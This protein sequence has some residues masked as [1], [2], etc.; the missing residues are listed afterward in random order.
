MRSPCDM[1][2]SPQ[3]LAL[4]Y[5]LRLDASEAFIQGYVDGMR[6]DQR[7]QG[8]ACGRGWIPRSKKCSRDK[9][10][11]T[12]KEAKAK[13]VEKAKERAKLKS[14]V[15]S[16]KGQKPYVKPKP[17]ETKPKRPAKTKRITLKESLETP[18]EKRPKITRIAD[19]FKENDAP[20][21]IEEG[22]F[23]D[24]KVYAED[25]YSDNYMIRSQNSGQ[26]ARYYAVMS[27]G[28]T[29]G[30]D[31]AFLLSQPESYNRLKK[32]LARGDIQGAARQFWENAGEEERK[33]IANSEDSL[34]TFKKSLSMGERQPVS[35]TNAVYAPD[36]KAEFHRMM[37]GFDDGSFESPKDIG[38]ARQNAA[39][40][41][42]SRTDLGMVAEQVAANNGAFYTRD[43]MEYINPD[44]LAQHGG[45]ERIPDVTVTS[46][47]FGREVTE[48][49][50]RTR[51]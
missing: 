2:P 25:A 31:S 13:T 19:S 6:L 49:M 26:L 7:G 14:E 33:A 10:S 20:Y 30:L 21:L 23:G 29:Q 32:S 28:T 37:V 44:A 4:H 17:V 46:A 22:P 48:K 45:L 18:P 16:A 47:Y 35:V 42:P 27:D 38:I 12:S 41:K 36:G 1:A 34:E 43:M 11:Q 3:R 8:V 40:G 24:R 39:T 15:K 9:A 51:S 5:G 50:R